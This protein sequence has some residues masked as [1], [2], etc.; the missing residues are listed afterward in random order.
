V[1]VYFPRNNPEGQP[2]VFCSSTCK[3]KH[4]VD[5]F[6]WELKLKAI[7][8]L[9]GVCQKCG[10]KKLPH[11]LEFHHRDPSKKEFSLGLPH[12]RSWEKMKAE[13]DKCDLLCANCHRE[14]EFMLL[15][16]KHEFFSELGIMVPKH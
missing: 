10:Y 5:K 11:A 12:T 9:G 8:Y 1:G 6:R 2:R 16:H 3:N 15:T 7:A 14:A 4:F 13:I